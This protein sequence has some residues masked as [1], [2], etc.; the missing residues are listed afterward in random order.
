MKRDLFATWFAV[1][2]GIR[3]AYVHK[4]N[5]NCA[6]DCKRLL[7]EQYIAFSELDFYFV[8]IRDYKGV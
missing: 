3:Y 1:V 4:A 7:K 5:I 6:D 2:N 8:F